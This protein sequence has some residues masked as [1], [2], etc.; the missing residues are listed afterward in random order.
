MISNRFLAYFQ[1]SQVSRRQ[2]MGS[3]AAG[4]TSSGAI[5]EAFAQAGIR[6]LHSPDDL[7]RTYEYLIIGAGSAGC[8][9]ARRLAE[10]GRSIL[11]IEAGGP[12]TLPA[13]SVPP[14]WPQ[15]QGSSADWRYVTVP[16]RHLGGRIIP[17]PRGKVVGGSSTINALAYQRGH[18]AA[19]DRWP[20]GWRFADL[21]PYFR[22][23]ETFSGG[24]NEWRGG[25]GPLHVLSLADVGD[26]TPLASAFFAAARGL[27]FP[28]TKDIGGEY[29]TGV[30]WNQLNIKGHKRDDAA[31]AYLGSLADVKVDLLVG[32]QVQKL[33]IENGRCMGVQLVNRIVH[34][35]IETLLCA[36]AIDSPR[37]LMLSG[38]GPADHMSSFDI[39]VSVDL[40]D[41]GSH[42]EDHLLLA[43]VAYSA[44]QEVPRSHYNHA[45]AM[46]YVPNRDPSESPDLL[47]MCLSIP[48][49]LPSVGK[50]APPAYVLVPCLMKPRSRGSVRLA[51]ADTSTPALIDPNYLQDSL[52]RDVLVEGVRLAREIGSTTAFAD[53]RVDEVYPGARS[54]SL[55]EIHTFISR[56]ANSFHHPVG[57]C[58]IGKVVDDTLHVK[59]I[60]GLRVVD[61]SVM[62]GIPQ[63]V[64]NAA[65]IA[66][67]E[68]ASDLILAR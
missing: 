48:F 2:A 6:V 8:V 40:P 18:R 64:I 13:I 63:A 9:L 34:P 25:D 30:G 45:D 44:R 38:I 51:S 22:R 39:R 60:A 11:V 62:P 23:A 68:R 47:I 58:R 14:D 56:A 10:A 49:V 31:T 36:G 17:Y 53:W 42:L 27:G 59:G 12:A 54:V 35:E 15:L 1:S 33:H 16:Q 41:V 20:V 7:G 5:W 32:S 57:T 52:D 66:V 3:I 26:R 28:E 50:L 24:S 21:L 4:L 29:A 65:T 67:A 46:L 55:G 61:A 43:G 37:I 19:F